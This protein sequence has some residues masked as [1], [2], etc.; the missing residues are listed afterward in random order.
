MLFQSLASGRIPG[1][2]LYHSPEQA[3]RWLEYHRAW[4]PSRTEDDLLTLYQ[5][6][7]DMTAQNLNEPSV[8]V[9][10]LGCGGGQKDRLLLQT[11]SS[12]RNDSALAYHPLDVSPTLVEETARITRE[13][14]PS[15]SSFPLAIDLEATPDL[16][17]LLPAN[18]TSGTTRVFTCFGMLPNF[19]HNTFPSYLAGLL[20]PNDLLLISA[21]L[22]PGA[23]WPEDAS[24]ILP[25]YDNS[26]AH[27]W[28]KGALEMLGA[29]SE[30]FQLKIEGESLSP[31]GDIWRVVVNATATTPIQLRLSNHS[32]D[33]LPEN[34]LEIFFS[35]RFSSQAIPELFE[36][37]GLEVLHSWIHSTGEE[38]IYLCG[39]RQ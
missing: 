1:K 35:N 39:R 32:F 9:I 4:S 20:G 14:L 8:Q 19:P 27:H 5:A 26:H 6:A 36:S 3:N 25:Q 37:A 15:L 11:I 7:F 23:G 21:N 18:N 10:G 31:S 33:W 28:Y 22:S 34:A 29:P 30:A 13:A 16:L 12:A 24:L 2:W 38:G 17:N